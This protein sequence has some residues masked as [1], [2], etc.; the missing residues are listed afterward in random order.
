MLKKNFLTSDGHLKTVFYHIPGVTMLGLTKPRVSRGAS[1]F[2]FPLP[3]I[4]YEQHAA[5]MTC[6]GPHFQAPRSVV[7]ILASPFISSHETLGKLLNFSD[8]QFL[9][10]QNE[11][12]E[13][14]L[15]YCDDLVWWL[16]EKTCIKALSAPQY[17]K[18][19]FTILQTIINIIFKIE[20]DN[21]CY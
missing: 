20:P 8:D 2:S 11:A 13:V 21:L 7:C 17:G 14:A 18:Q 16:S 9:H 10:L 6:L 15:S 4:T 19:M 1:S 12:S 3:P 5:S